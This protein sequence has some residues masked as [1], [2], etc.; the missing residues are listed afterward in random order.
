MFAKLLNTLLARVHARYAVRVRY[1]CPSLGYC[2]KTH[3]ATSYA[4]A[5]AWVACYDKGDV[6]HIYVAR[7]GFAQP[8]PC[9][10]RAIA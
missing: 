5:L 10:M 9:G 2:Y 7:F 8:A 6:A 1:V 3:Y 4:D